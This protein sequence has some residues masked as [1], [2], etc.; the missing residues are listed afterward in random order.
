MSHHDQHDGTDG[1][2][3]PDDGP[4]PAHQRPEGV[5]DATI[6]ALGRLGKALDLCEESRGHLY[7]FHRRT[8]DTERCLREAVELLHEAGHHDLAER[9]DTEVVGR[10][11]IA[12][13]WTF[14]LVEDYDEGYYRT[15]L[16]VEQAARDQLVQGRKHVHESEM[17]ESHRTHG[18]RGHESRPDALGE[19]GGATGG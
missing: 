13:R 17:K 7:A 11:V 19:G 8:G 6:E 1:V 14:Q 5:D 2:Q 12:G 16:D 18:R 10:N 3:R 15:F 9:V 4:D